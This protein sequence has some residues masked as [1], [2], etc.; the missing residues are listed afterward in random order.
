[1]NTAKI[2]RGTSGWAYRN[3]VT[4]FFCK[5]INQSF[6]QPFN[7]LPHFKKNIFV[8]QFCIILFLLLFTGQ[9]FSQIKIHKNINRSDGLVYSQVLCMLEDSQGF[10]W[11]GT[12]AGLSRWDGINFKNFTKKDGLKSSSIHSIAQSTDGT[13]YIGTRSGLNIF[14]DDKIT[15]DPGIPEKLNDRINDI[16]VLNNSTIYFA[17]D[18]SGLWVYDGQGYKNITAEDGLPGNRIKCIKMGQDNSILIGTIDN[19]LTVYKKNKFEN[20]P[21]PSGN[22][23]KQINAIFVLPNGNLLIGTDRG[24][25]VYNKNKTVIVDDKTGLPDNFITDICA[26]IDD[27]IYIATAQGIAVFKENKIIDII[28]KQ[29]GLSSSFIWEVLKTSSGIYFIGTDG[30]GLDIFIPK[31]IE[32]FTAESGLPH[33]N[34]WSIVES[35]DKSI[36]FGTDNGLAVLKNGRFKTYN[37]KDGLNSDMIITIYEARNG[38]IYLGT[39]LFGVNIF[40]DNR[41]YG[42]NSKNGLT[43]DLV[44]SIN[45]DQKGNIYFGTYDSGICVYDGERIVDTLSIEDGLPGNSITTVYKSDDGELYFGTEKNGAFKLSND[46]TRKITR[47]ITEGTVWSILKDNKSSKLYFG[48]DEM[49]LFIYENGIVDTINTDD[50]LSNNTVIGIMQ[51]DAGNLYLTTDNGF[52]VLSFSDDTFY[53]RNISIEDGLASNECNQG[54]YL[55]DSEGNFWIG[56]VS[57]VSK[58]RPE[59]DLQTLSAPKMHFTKMQLFNQDVL[60]TRQDILQNFKYNENYFNFEYVGI[61]LAVQSKVVYKYRLSGIDNDWVQTDRRFVQYTNLN[62]GEY[63]FSVKAKNHWGIWSKPA[64]ITFSISPPFWKSWWFALIAAGMILFPIALIIYTRIHRLLA[65]ERL[66]AKISSDLHDDIGAGLSEISILSA[67][68]DA[69]SPPELR[70]SVKNELNKIGAMSRLLIESMSDIVW[71]INPKTDSLLDL[72]TRLKD[73]FSD[74]FELKN[75][76]FKTTNLAQLG[77]EHLSM[78]K[79]QHV[80][81]I[82]KE[83]I[84]NA[85]KYSECTKLDLMI[86]IQK[87][88]LLIHLRDDGKGFDPET[89]KKGNGLLN[90]KRRAEKAGGSLIIN[91]IPGNG[92]EVIFTG[93]R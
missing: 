50:G 41:F 79:R 86:E 78:E 69:K 57:G 5:V 51:D 10:L 34:V 52:N 67:V 92:T 7:S 62:S 25:I 60:F 68:V 58:Y 65:V 13:I 38:V 17:G 1:M 27:E 55:K 30:T 6:Y 29:N 49:G 44:W 61:D 54:A 70:A 76:E 32:N 22:K 72:F 77:K 2:Q 31:N 4:P 87:G 53:L 35:K 3:W 43:S 19:G 11:I 89:I 28:S 48:V 46:G 12:S 23:F 47:L 85:V 56:T 36:Y 18:K 90:M 37:T 24:L 83:A 40:K 93:K 42:M 14:R 73:S 33:S 80:F 21:L 45:E 64:R 9:L 84:N 26:G 15:H 16:L 75:I 8:R 59:N 66:R 81:L 20:I 63:I 74:I 82:F 88:K 39:D 91:A 71:L